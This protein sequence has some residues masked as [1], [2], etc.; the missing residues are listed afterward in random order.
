MDRKDITRTGITFG[1][2]YGG[3][4]GDGSVMTKLGTGSKGRSV[5]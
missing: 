3:G 2:D 4:G 1:N 5:A